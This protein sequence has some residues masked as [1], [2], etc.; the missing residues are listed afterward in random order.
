MTVAPAYPLALQRNLILGSL[1]VLAAIAWGVLLWQA[2]LPGMAAMGGTM[3]G[4]PLFL[5]IWVMMMIAMM[6]P[7]AAPMI[8]LFHRVQLNR[9][10]NGQAFVATWIFVATYLALWTAAGVLAYAAAAAS[11]ALLAHAGLNA[12][13]TARIGGGLIVVAGLYQLPPLKRVCLSECRSPMAF[14]ATSWRDGIGGAIAMGLRHG[15]ACLGCCW[16]LFVILFPLGIMNIAAMAL[17]TV[18]IFAEK[19]FPWSRRVAQAGAAALIAYGLVVIA[20][21][22]ALPT[23][24]A[25]AL[26]MTMPDQPGGMG[27]MKM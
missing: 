13:A 5:A 18:F 4:A 3:G 12:E 7:T 6:F 9:R 2:S 8:L 27:D 21:P 19:V 26:P 14:V 15:L 22:T 25:D 17:I 11:E 1:L 20:V 16:L 23:F 24:A 10:S